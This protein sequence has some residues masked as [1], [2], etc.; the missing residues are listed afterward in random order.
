MRA[1]ATIAAYL[2]VLAGLTCAFVVRPPLTK[3]RAHHLIS[4]DH[5]HAANCVAHH[6]P[7]L[8]RMSAGE[9][10]SEDARTADADAP[11]VERSNG[12]SNLK[13]LVLEHLDTS[14]LSEAVSE[15][16]GK[17]FTIRM[18]MLTY[19]T[20]TW[21]DLRNAVNTSPCVCPSGRG[22]DASMLRAAR[23]YWN[24]HCKPNRDY[25][26]FYQALLDF[27]QK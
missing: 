8:H 15:L 24:Y 9:A 18:N 26:T 12:Q 25:R 14:E 4:A 1:L 17:G 23:T 6:A 22:V 7:W 3:A 27:D 13:S 20:C 5:A 19:R 21:K 16:A 11:Q 10:A 2:A